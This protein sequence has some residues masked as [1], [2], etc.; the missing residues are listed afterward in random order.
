MSDE[1]EGQKDFGPDGNG[2]FGP[3]RYVTHVYFSDSL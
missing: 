2:A 3:T 1:A